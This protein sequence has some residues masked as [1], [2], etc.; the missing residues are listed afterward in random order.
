MN[1]KIVRMHQ[2]LRVIKVIK[3]KTNLKDTE[4][5]MTLKSIDFLKKR[6]NFSAKA[7]LSKFKVQIK[8]QPLGSVKNTYEVQTWR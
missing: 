1:R 4:D 2:E 7:M 6:L 5:I 8:I 3:V